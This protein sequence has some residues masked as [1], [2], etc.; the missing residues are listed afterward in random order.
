LIWA[1]TTPVKTET[2]PGPTNARVDAR[3]AIA[4]AAIQST[5]MVL[6]DQHALMTQHPDLHQDAVHFNDQGA[7]IQ[8]KQAAQIIR[9]KLAKLPPQ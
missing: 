4:Q 7:A 5:G 6:D 3:N 9:E 8:G 1:T 2:Q